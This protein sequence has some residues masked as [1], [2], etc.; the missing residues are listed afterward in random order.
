MSKEIK[1]RV[2]FSAPPKRVYEALMD[3]KEHASFT[4][5]KARI[6]RKVGGNVAAYGPYISGLNVELIDG[7][8]IVQAW[9]GNDWPKGDYSIATFELNRAPG[10]K[11]K[12][13]F[14]QSGVPNEHAKNIAQGWKDHYWTKLKRHL[15]AA[16]TTTA[17]K[18]AAP[19]TSKRRATKRAPRRR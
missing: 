2:T 7:K 9:R 5:A 18:P 11:T 12:L 14:T 17:A 13:V 6:S 8:R 10:G 1:Q 4:G 19:K 16:E 3:S 15:A